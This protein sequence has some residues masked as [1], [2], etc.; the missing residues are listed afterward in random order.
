MDAGGAVRVVL[1]RLGAGDLDSEYVTLTCDE[2]GEH[3]MHQG[4]L[5]VP[6][7][8]HQSRRASGRWFVDCLRGTVAPQG[9]QVL[10]QMLQ[11]WEQASDQRLPTHFD[12]P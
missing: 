11:D 12:L 7:C 8:H 2:M 5:V 9:E 1:G 10:V 6:S 4:I 3:C